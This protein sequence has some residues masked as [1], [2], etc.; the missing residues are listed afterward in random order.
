MSEAWSTKADWMRGT[1]ATE[2][3]WD[4]LGNLT[5]LKLGPAP[6]PTDDDETET[7]PILSPQ[8]REQLAREERRRIAS[9]S[10][11]GPVR[12]LNEGD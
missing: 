3:T 10:S 1:G 7:Q 6:Q 11:G 9:A 5:M 4:S 8:K 2:A 12:R